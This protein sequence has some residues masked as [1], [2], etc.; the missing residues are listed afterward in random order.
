MRWM[1]IK[2]NG[3]VYNNI[4]IIS[5]KLV[6]NEVWKNTS[7]W[8]R[9]MGRDPVLEETN[10][11]LEMIYF[12]GGDPIKYEYGKYKKK[13]ITIWDFEDEDDVYNT[14]NYF[15]P[16][17]AKKD[18]INKEVALTLVKL[19]YKSQK[20]NELLIHDNKEIRELAAEVKKMYQV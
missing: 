11:G 17:S 3:H 18:Q 13:I 10:Y 5:L 4:S 12:D 2:I 8:S 14:I 6:E 16:N 20:I 19:L 1:D 9:M 15:G 7:I